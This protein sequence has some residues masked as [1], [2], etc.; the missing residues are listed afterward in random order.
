VCLLFFCSGRE[1][2][3]FQGK[4]LTLLGVE[5]LLQAHKLD[6]KEER[7]F[8]SL[9]PSSLHFFSPANGSGWSASPR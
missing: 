4:G 5:I 1:K 6:E 2:N 7:S 3:E 8:P 9:P